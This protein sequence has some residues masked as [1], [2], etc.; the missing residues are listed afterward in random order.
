MWAMMEKLR[1]FFINKLKTKKSGTRPGRQAWFLPAQYE[2]SAASG[3]RE[4][5]RA[6][7]L[8]GESRLMKAA[9]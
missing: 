5:P 9:A 7:A 6:S 8:S 4:V 2:K 1:M 3:G